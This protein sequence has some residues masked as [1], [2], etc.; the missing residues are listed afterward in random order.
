[1]HPATA[2]LAL[3]LHEELADLADFREVLARESLVLQDNRTD[4]LPPLTARKADLAQR[5]GQRLHAREAVLADMGHASGA[6]GMGAW[7]AT[8]PAAMRDEQSGHWQ[9]LLLL[10]QE[11]RDEHAL[12]GELITLLMTRNQK[13]LTALLSAGGQPLTYGP[14]GQQRIGAGGGRRLGS[15]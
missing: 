1:V 5:L 3:M 11:C 14:D 4:D 9:R 10:A 8:L 2:K 6:T 15:A 7:L 13:A 12:N